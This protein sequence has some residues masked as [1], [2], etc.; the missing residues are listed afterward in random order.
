M[1]NNRELSTQIRQ[2]QR[3]LE[4]N[5][6]A[7]QKHIMADDKVRT[8]KA[9]SLIDQENIKK[10]KTKAAKRKKS[11]ADKRPNKKKKA[12][13][14]ENNEMSNDEG[15][16]SDDDNS[17]AEEMKWKIV[18]HDDANKNKLWLTVDTM[19][20]D[21]VQGEE[22]VITSTPKGLIEDGFGALVKSYIEE[23]NLD[24]EKWAAVLKST[25]KT[26]AKK[27]SPSKKKQKEQIV[28]PRETGEQKEGEV[29][30]MQVCLHN[31]YKDDI[32]YKSENNASFCSPGN[33]LYGIA[34]AH[35]KVSFIA[36]SKKGSYRPTTNKPVYCC[37]NYE[38][39]KNK[40]KSGVE[41]C[42]HAICHP[43][44][45]KGVV[46]AEPEGISVTRKRSR[47]S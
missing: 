27:K 33:Y 43:C 45:A 8:E 38:G 21:T 39:Q 11:A 20:E 26:E 28:E 23:N 41:L 32:T 6:T 34:C 31:V 47:Q 18:G 29:T 37:V 16:V 5:T 44:W 30:K 24:M 22:R 46:A 15:T 35:C 4:L 7:A 17:I 1:K 14:E 12:M 19:E 42:R 9:A 40:K 3:Q 25:T 2:L 10:H 36:E 13:E